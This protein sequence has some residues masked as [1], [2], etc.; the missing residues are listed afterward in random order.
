MLVLNSADITAWV[1][2]FIWPFFRVAA[3]LSL[4]PVLGTSQV[5][6]RIRV[7][8]AVFITVS[9]L[10]LVGEIPKVEPLGSAG[11]LLVLNQILIGVLMGFSLSIVFNAIILAGQSIAVTMGLGFAL[12]ND[13]QNGTQVP[14]VG[15]FYNL[16]ATLLFLVL[17]GHHAIL[18]LMADSFKY[19]PIT[20]K[21]EIDLI[22]ILLEW[23]KVLFEGALKIALPAIIAMLT[24]NVVMGIMTRA[25]PQLN[26]FSVGFPI[27][28]TVGFLA[29]LAGLPA[30]VPDME[31]LL[32]GALS[33]IS[34]I[35]SGVP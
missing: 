20:M 31:N 15:Q 5:P 23:S 9:M 25:A 28:M 19:L 12:M 2:S 22:W 10:P 1:G 32:A 34:K 13:P 26:V 6:S 14:V 24:V 4:V 11:I 21:L 17:N 29:I 7:L 3:L 30:F 18:Q 35:I 33:N 27:T 16:M 8:L